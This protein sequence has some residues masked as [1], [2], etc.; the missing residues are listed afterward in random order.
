MR[1]VVRGILLD[2]ILGFFDQ[3]IAFAE[4]GRA[5]RAYFRASGLLPGL[6]SIRAHNALAHPGI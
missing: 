6:Q 2:S 4:L 3:I 1:H 5:R